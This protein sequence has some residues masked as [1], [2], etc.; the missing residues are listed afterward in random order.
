[1]DHSRVLCVGGIQQNCKQQ[2]NHQHSI[3]LHGKCSISKLIINT[4]HTRLLHAGP[5]LMSTSLGCHFYFLGGCG[6]IRFVIYNCIICKCRSPR[7][8]SPLMS[9][10]PAEHITPDFVFSHVGVDYAGPLLIKHEY[11]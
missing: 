9:Q 7:P 10:L 8:R 4:E 2:Y 3:I 5:L 11:I 1:M 6:A